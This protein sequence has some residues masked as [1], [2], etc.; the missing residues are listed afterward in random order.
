[1]A[2]ASALVNEPRLIVADEPTGA[3]DSRTSMEVMEIFQELGR[4]GVTILLVDQMAA[5]TLTVA[6]RGYVLASGH[7]VRAGDASSLV[8]DSALEAAYLG[9]AQAA[10][11]TVS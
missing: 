6:D 10:E 7:I 3:L 11:R 4:A 1:V 9:H 2:I 8:G 5:S